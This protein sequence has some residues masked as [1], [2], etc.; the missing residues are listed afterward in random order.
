MTKIEWTDELFPMP[1]NMTAFTQ[2]NNVKPMRL[3][4]TKVVMVFLRWFATITTGQCDW[5]YH[6]SALDFITDRARSLGS[7][8]TRWCFIFSFLAN[9]HTSAINAICGKPISPTLIRIKLTS[10]PPRFTTATPLETICE[11]IKIFVKWNTYSFSSDFHYT[12]S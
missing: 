3:F 9:L 8:F 12:N 2:W 11:I 5:L 7:Q 4:I 10:L 1:L 6:S